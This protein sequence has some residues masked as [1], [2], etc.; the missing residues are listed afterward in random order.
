LRTLNELDRQA[1]F[2]RKICHHPALAVL[3]ILSIGNEP[4]SLL[5]VGVIM[6]VKCRHLL[7]LNLV[8]RF[9]ILVPS[10]FPEVVT[11][12]TVVS[13]LDGSTKSLPREKGK[14]G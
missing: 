9:D 2:F 1:E 5:L 12:L 7:P 3:Q 10:P 11:I 13:L 6:L 8:Q 4:P 14:G